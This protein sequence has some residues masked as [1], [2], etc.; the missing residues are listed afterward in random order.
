ML[1][2][3]MSDGATRNVEGAVMSDGKIYDVTICHE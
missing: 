1:D 2:G 3:T